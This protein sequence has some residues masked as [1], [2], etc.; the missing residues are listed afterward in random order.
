MMTICHKK[1]VLIQANGT[2]FIIFKYFMPGVEEHRRGILQVISIIDLYLQVLFI[3]SMVF[4]SICMHPTIPPVSNDD[5]DHSWDDEAENTANSRKN[6]HQNVSFFLTNCCSFLLFIFLQAHTGSFGQNPE[7]ILRAGCTI[8]PIITCGTR[9][10]TLLTNIVIIVI[11][12]T[13]AFTKTC[14][15]IELAIGFT[16]AAFQICMDKWPKSSDH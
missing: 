4:M 11:I 3:F 15:L 12:S 14:I 2:Y 5:T 6:H 16:L 7:I 13:H 8:P 9:T 10:L 1:R